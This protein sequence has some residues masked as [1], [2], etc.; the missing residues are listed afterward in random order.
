MTVADVFKNPTFADMTRVC[1]LSNFA[2]LIAKHRR[3]SVLPVKSLTRS[4]PEPGAKALK[5][6]PRAP[7]NQRFNFQSAQA[8][9]G[10]TSSQWC[11]N[12]PLVMKLPRVAIHLHHSKSV[13]FRKRRN[14]CSRNGP[15]SRKIQHPNHSVCQAK[16][17]KCLRPSMRISP[18]PN[19]SRCLEI[20]MSTVSSRRSRFS[21]VVFL[22]YSP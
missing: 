13:S 22:T 19:P 2:L 3:L 20:P 17:G 8:L 9:H 6:H 10:A 11:P 21:R 14:K 16:G 5:M 12:T 7:P 18:L 1:F 15:D 4:C